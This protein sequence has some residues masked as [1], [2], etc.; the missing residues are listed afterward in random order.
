MTKTREF[1]E[2]SRATPGY[3]PR[4]LIWLPSPTCCLVA[5]SPS[6]A[7]RRL[8]FL[9][10]ANRVRKEHPGVSAGIL[11]QLRRS[12]VSTFLLIR[13]DTWDIR[14]LRCGSTQVVACLLPC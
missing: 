3:S 13:S 6:F 14:A 8:N 12:Q 11:R 4:P 2:V 10:D 7:P 1:S 9:H 5:D